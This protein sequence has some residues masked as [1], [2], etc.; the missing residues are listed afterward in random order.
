MY[1]D[2]SG[3]CKILGTSTIDILRPSEI[4]DFALQV[5]VERGRIRSMRW[6]RAAAFVRCERC[7]F[8]MELV[9]VK[10]SMARSLPVENLLRQNVGSFI[11][12]LQ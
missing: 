3:L 1:K 10:S 2:Y 4:K 5:R 9:K 7:V 11:N 12:Y 6:L 8:W